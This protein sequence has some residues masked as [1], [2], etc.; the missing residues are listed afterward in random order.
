MSSARA[1]YVATGFGQLRVFVAGTGRAVLVLPGLISGAAMLA[2]RLA[3]SASDMAFHVLELPGIGGSAGV[4]I[5][6]AELAI[7]AAAEALDLAGAPVLAFDLA[8]TL[9]GGLQG[10]SILVDAESGRAWA[11]Q[12][13]ALAEFA[14]RADGT[15]LVALFDH[16]RD[17]HMLDPAGAGRVAK[18]GDALPD[19]V[20][21]DSTV[22]AAAVCPQAYAE[23]WRRCTAAAGAMPPGAG[24]LE[25]A[26]AELRRL[27]ITEAI[28][29]PPA[30]QG[31]GPWCDY[32]DLPRG[33]QHLRRSGRS[34]RLLIAL[35]SAPGSA[36]PLMPLLDGLA[37]G[38]RIAAP[39]YFGNGDSDKPVGRVDIARLA[40]D[41]LDLTDALGETSFD[42]WG[43]HTGALIALDAA[44]MA[45]GRVGRLV[46]EAPPMLPP[47]FAAD[48]LA[49]YFPP[50][51][52]H[53]WGLHLR[54]AW[55]MRRDMF[56]FWPWYRAERAA[57]RPMRLPDAA[58]LHDW[59]V[60]LL[61]SGAT[62]DRTYRAAFEYDTRAALSRVATPALVCAGPMDML[63]DGLA[64][65]AR[66][67][68]GALT[69]A[70]TPATVWYPHQSEA[71]IAATLAVYDRFLG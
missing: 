17:C 61:K 68:N 31:D 41:T 64:G 43:T 25:D 16:F 5:S 67:G 27:P 8:G 28:S 54:Q 48:I 34:G 42:I 21:L 30:A 38:R 35:Q 9:G 58:F 22:V 3:Q 39:D 70:S 53:E 14:P 65:I 63:A 11:S 60:G 36:A 24:S 10:P 12:A 59:T 55:C 49:N 15:H 71:D 7:A 6:D 37:G 19:A 69:V 56:L 13:L 40:Q 23:L 46:L 33:R 29:V 47:D 57:G 32:I 52:A 62:Y 4:R 44:L 66:L 51:L 18:I 45:P 50:L 20:E 1:H 26:I 2:A